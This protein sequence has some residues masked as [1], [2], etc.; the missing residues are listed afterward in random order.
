MLFLENRTPVAAPLDNT[1]P[2][3]ECAGAVECSREVA[4]LVLST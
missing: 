3:G 2:F 4:H 1:Q